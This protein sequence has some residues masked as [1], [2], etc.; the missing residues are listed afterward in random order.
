L[1]DVTSLL[2]A[3]LS[4]FWM[5][6]SLHLQCEMTDICGNIPQNYQKFIYSDWWISKFA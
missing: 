1:N 3:I 5:C 2:L 4:T 6:C